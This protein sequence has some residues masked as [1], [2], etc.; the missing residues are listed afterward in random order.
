M[1]VIDIHNKENTIQ[2]SILPDYGGMMARLTYKGRKIISFYPDKVHLSAVL[3]CGSPILF[4]FA[5]RTAGDTYRVGEKDYH[6]PFHGLVKEAAFGVGEVCF[7]RVVL[8]IE[9]SAVSREENYPFDWKLEISYKLLDE[10]IQCTAR[11]MNR[12]KEKL[13][14][15]FGWH[16]FFVASRKEEF[17]L[18]VNMTEYMDW[19]TGESYRSPSLMDCTKSSDFVFTG[20][21]DK[22]LKIQNT[23]D[24]YEALIETSDAYKAL[25]VCSTFDRRVCVEPWIGPPD[26][27]HQAEYLEYVD[28][29]AVREYPMT[30]SLKEV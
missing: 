17:A 1:R 13:F 5:G 20:R 16:P 27:V 3:S 6:M 9:S 12:S 22:E 14:H 24:G 21:T 7:D 28:L 8:W 10:Q 23:A 29:G 26:S 15:S 25:V 18:T 19:K 11:V 4:P 30:I 2:A